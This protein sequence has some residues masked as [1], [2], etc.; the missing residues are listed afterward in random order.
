MSSA[1][2]IDV[3]EKQTPS[4]EQPLSELIS[5]LTEDTSRLFRQEVAL[6]RAEIK[7]EASVAMVGAAM[8]AMA[9]ALSAVAL[10]LLSL[11]AAEGLQRLFDIDLAWCYFIVA[12]IWL[13]VAGVLFSKGKKKIAEVNP[14]PERTVESIKDAADTLK[15]QS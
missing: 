13:I 14:K 15:G 10:I 5:N 4:P 8:M 1:D 2:N 11:A 3:R 9:G 12:V 6:A 7:Q